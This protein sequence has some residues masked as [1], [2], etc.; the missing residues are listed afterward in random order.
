M[1]ISTYRF[2][3]ISPAAQEAT[4]TAQISI[5]HGTRK[6]RPPPES[7][8]HAEQK[9]NATSQHPNPNSQIP[10]LQQERI[11]SRGS[12]QGQ[13]DVPNLQSNFAP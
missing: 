5:D 1:I 9:P 11:T 3:I 6:T 7:V 8:A 12:S 10:N 13:P 2:E 4:F